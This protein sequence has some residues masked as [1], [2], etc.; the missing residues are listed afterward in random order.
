[1]HYPLQSSSDFIWAPKELLSSAPWVWGAVL[2]IAFHTETPCQWH[3]GK[4]EQPSAGVLE[5]RAVQV[6]SCLQEH[7]FNQSSWDVWKDHPAT[8]CPSFRP[9]GQEGLRS[10]PGAQQCSLG[11]QRLSDEGALLW[12]APSSGVSSSLRSALRYQKGRRWREESHS[13]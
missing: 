5:P 2:V 13:P 12:G 4:M 9:Q 7:T 1:M 3:P 8:I 10:H 6:H 11:W